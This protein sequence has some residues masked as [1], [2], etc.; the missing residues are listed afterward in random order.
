MP[1]ADW[2]IVSCTPF[3]LPPLS[4]Q[5]AIASALSDVDALITALE[6]LIIKK[7]NIKQGAMQELLTGKKRLPGFGGEWEVLN[8]DEIADVKG[9]KRLPEGKSLSNSETQHPYIRV[10]DMYQGGVSL[11]KIKYVPDNVFPSIKNYLISK[12]DLFI[13]VAGTLGIVGKIPPILNGANLTEN[14][15]KLTNIKCNQD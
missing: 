1:R 6:Q 14:A 13:T 9:G 10:A 7:R 12:D 2:K 15:D 5:K 3:P 4:E 11:E 8:I